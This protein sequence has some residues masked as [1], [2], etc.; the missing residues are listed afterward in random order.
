MDDTLSNPKGSSDSSSLPSSGGLW[1]AEKAKVT[2]PVCQNLVN[3]AFIFQNTF[4]SLTPILDVFLPGV[5]SSFSSIIFSSVAGQLQENH[6]FYDH[7]AHLSYSLVSLAHPSTL[8]LSISLCCRLSWV[9][10]IAST[11]HQH[12]HLPVPGTCTQDQS[13]FLS[14]TRR[15]VS[16]LVHV[17]ILKSARRIL[18]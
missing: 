2:A 10:N 15:L 17:T 9:E 11:P 3:R 14:G 12:L 6:C 13:G 4:C 5:L 18:F 8:G 7:L 1:V 16:L